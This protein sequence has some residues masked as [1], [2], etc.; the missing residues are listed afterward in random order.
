MAAIVVVVVAALLVAVPET[1]VFLFRQFPVV[2]AGVEVV[3]V[4]LAL[5]L[6]R[7]A[8]LQLEADR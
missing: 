3:L 1:S 4:V 2:G 6:W 8:E 5:L 7:M